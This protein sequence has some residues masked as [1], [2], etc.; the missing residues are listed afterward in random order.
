MLVAAGGLGFAAQVVLL[1]ELLATYAGNEL[2]AGVAVAVWLLCE[3]LGACLFG[4]WA[5][6]YNPRL[7]P[8]IGLISVASSVLAVPATIAARSSL[9][10]LPGEAVSVPALVGISFMVL[11]LP[12][13][14]HGALFVTAAAG[15][16][17]A[18]RA[19]ALEGLGTA[20]AGALVSLILLNRLP[21][22]AVAALLAVPVAAGVFR[23]ARLL[24]A[25][26][27]VTLLVLA[28]LAGRAE[29]R[30][31]AA[32]WPGQ[33][34]TAIINTPYGKVVRMQRDGQRTVLYDGIPVMNI[35]PVDPERI[36]ELVHLPM[37]AHPAPGRVLMLGQ[38]LGGYVDELLKHPVRAVT[39]VQLDAGLGRELRIAGG[40]FVSDELADPRVRRV[41]ADP[42]TFVG[43]AGGTFDV[44]IML[45]E[46]PV[47]FAAGRLFALEFFE[48]C[49]QRLA[50]GGIL[51][52]PAPGTGT[53]IPP[54]A[55]SILLNRRRT[56]EA[57]FNALELLPA[58]F[59][60][61]LASDRHIQTTTETLTARLRQR[62]IVASVLDSSYLAALLD[63]F[64]REL[65]ERELSG[66]TRP[67]L[68]TARR[69]V[70]VLLS[71]ARAG[72]MSSPGFGR[73]YSGLTSLPLWYAWI[74]VVFLLA[75]GLVGVRWRGLPFGT[76]LAVLTSGL[77]GAGIYTCSVVGYQM[78]FGSVYS[79]VSLLAASLMLGSVIGGVL[80][81]RLGHR[82]APV[83]L[84]AGDL[85]LGAGAVA[86]P[87]LVQHGPAVSFALVLGLAGA[88]LGL[89]F[90]LAGSVLRSEGTGRMTG[91]LAAL[92]LTGGFAGGLVTALLLLPI[93]GL[94]SAVLVLA[95]VKL[96]SLVAQLAARS[97]VV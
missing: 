38:A 92:D 81:T 85:L 3:S 94:A 86:L 75:V 77:T 69:P 96:S 74:A 26:T 71:M 76:G 60:L 42:V 18:G 27:A 68:N 41:T 15:V 64:R 66:A 78:R 51:A 8:L 54:D 25:V 17:S 44:V 16:G 12:A 58:D 87:V 73:W 40:D 5:D 45:D 7:L 29:R 37:L 72:R 70:E 80:G 34:I 19:Y 67:V 93:Y 2:S 55:R 14:T 4:Q 89:Q 46:A 32:A 50:P 63:P 23:Q 49:R 28:V 65:L 84:V 36:E 97:A 30:V 52:I 48:R 83:L 90:A 13:A 82:G 10:L 47:T 11:V 79:G 1:R 39:V 33:H 56:L 21:S 95:G 88:C 62:H 22:L 61:L 9:G 59:P 43:G 91:V 24:S 35:P 6:W 53:Q 31:Y 57:S 20:A